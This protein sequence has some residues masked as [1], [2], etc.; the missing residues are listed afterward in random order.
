MPMTDEQIIRDVLGRMADEAPAALDFEELGHPTVPSK[1]SPPSVFGRKWAAVAA[2]VAALVVVVGAVLV[3]RPS[4][5]GA[6]PVGAPAEATVYELRSALASGFDALEVADGIEGVQEAYI[7]GHLSTKVWFTTRPEG[8]TV[9]VQ[10]ADIDVRDTAWWNMSAAPP[11][12]GERIVTTAW[13][14]VDDVVYQAGTPGGGDRPWRIA[15]DPPSGP[16]AF[17]LMYFDPEYGDQFREQLA[18]SDAEVTRRATANGGAIWMARYD[19]DGQSRFYIHPDGYLASW[20]W[21]ELTPMGRDSGPV[22]SGSITYTPLSYPDPITAPESGAPLDLADFDLPDDSLLQAPDGPEAEGVIPISDDHAANQ[23][24]TGGADY[25]EIHDRSQE[26]GLEFVCGRGAG[27]EWCAIWDDGVVVV[28]PFSVPE[29]ATATI[30]TPGYDGWIQSE[31][32][33]GE[34]FAIWHGEGR[35]HLWYER[36]GESLGGSGTDFPS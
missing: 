19:G 11:A 28:L 22:D 31:T 20:E 10:Q 5:D 3:F 1:K 27:A 34:P 25:Q 21:H 14:V 24:F 13:I 2:G 17:G 33:A 26:L 36:D 23:L 4:G 15:D 18:P 8:D 32:Q 30:S 6:T 7:R 9:V 16:L 29:D 35:F 12:V